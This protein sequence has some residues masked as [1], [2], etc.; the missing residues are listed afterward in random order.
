[1]S[2]EDYAKMCKDGFKPGEM[3]GEESV[4]IMD[5]IKAV[6]AQAG[7][8]VAGYNDDLDIDKLK[9]ITGSEVKANALGEAMRQADIPQTEANAKKINDA[10]EELQGIDKITD[11]GFQYMLINGLRPTI[12]N[13][14]MANY[15]AGSVQRSHIKGYYDLGMQGY[16]AQK[17]DSTNLDGIKGDIEKI[18]D[19]LEIDGISRDSQ[20]EEATWLIRHGLDIT[21]NNIERLNQLLNTKL[22][23]DY[24]EA[25]GKAAYTLAK[26]SEPKSTDLSDDSINV[27]AKASDILE[28]TNSITDIQLSNAVMVGRKINLAN[29]WSMEKTQTA[30]NNV[31]Q[32]NEELQQSRVALEEIRLRMT[33]DVNVS[34]LKRGI[35]IDTMP[36][37]NL[38][39]TLKAGQ[40]AINESIYGKLENE[41]LEEKAGIFNSTRNAID[42]IPYMPAA[43]IGRLKLEEEYSLSKVHEI[44]SDLKAR[45]EAASEQYETLMTAPRKDMGDSFAKA[46][47]NV[48]DILEDLGFEKN[49]KNAKAVRILG[50]NSMEIN[51]TEV[52]KIREATDRV[53]DVVDKLTPARTIELIRQGVNPMEMSID[54]LS[55]VLNELDIAESDDKYSRFL[56]KLEKS[57]S[58]TS[59]E[60]AAYIGIYRLVHRLEKTDGAAI[61]ALVNGDRNITFKSLLEGMR[62]RGVSFD[63]AIDD[64]YGF[65][66]D[67][68]QKGVSISDQIQQAFSGKIGYT[69]AENLDKEYIKESYKEYINTISDGQD[70]VNSM[71]AESEVLTVDNIAAYEA[72]NSN[73]KNV[74][75]LL[76]RFEKES[77]KAANDKKNDYK[78]AMAGLINNFEDRETA[79]EAYDELVSSSSKLIEEYKYS[80]D[81]TIDLKQIMLCNKQMSLISNRSNQ[82]K[83]TIPLELNGDIAAINLTLKH[84][85]AANVVANFTDERF[86]RIT[87]HFTIEGEAVKGMVVSESVEGRDYLSAVVSRMSD[88]TDR[89]MDVN[90]IIGKEIQIFNAEN[91]NDLAINDDINNVDTKSLYQLAK[92]FLLEYSR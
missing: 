52:E 69:E 21:G 92:S 5:H 78:A 59:S 42:A 86:G 18:V 40:Q 47:R 87:A 43:V 55:D 57:N 26:G 31:S 81:N 25:A 30:G 44:G 67:K 2:E 12:D 71:L 24:K 76:N 56:Y 66:Q 34:L 39:E 72:I 68:V 28:K 17:A 64:N 54:K 85:E 14:Y 11:S 51:A 73:D 45:Y 29:V 22:P 4:T 36:L 88:N 79:R 75:G 48:D 89:K 20:I 15:S 41:V 38:V 19:G 46:F 74:F 63:E 77:R 10:A 9:E 84:G 8:V 6:M 70:I 33:L 49:E 23:V 35:E 32:I 82:E 61:G 60:R 7:Q 13:I 83:Y 3:T 37:S 91:D 80:V 62:S 50:Y 16:L 65:L 1:M 53:M 58:I 90:V 27:F